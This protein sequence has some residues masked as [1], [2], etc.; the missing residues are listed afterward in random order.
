MGYRTKGLLGIAEEDTLRQDFFM[1]ESL[2]AKNESFML[3]FLCQWNETGER[4]MRKKDDRTS[5]ILELL[6]KEKKL[7]VAE[8]SRIQTGRVRSILRLRI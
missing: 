1:L 5:R 4:I 3:Y 7:E 8:I 2:I 6:V